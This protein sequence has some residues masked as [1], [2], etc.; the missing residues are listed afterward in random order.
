MEKPVGV[1]PAKFESQ[2]QETVS[3]AYAICEGRIAENKCHM[4]PALKTLAAAALSLEQ[5]V[6]AFIA[7]EHLSK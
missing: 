6:R 4:T 5:A 7:A 1:R 3:L 2:A